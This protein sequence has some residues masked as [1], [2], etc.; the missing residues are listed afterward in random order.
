M[1]FLQVF[2]RIFCMESGDSTITPA[3][4][5]AKWSIDNFLAE[6]GSIRRYRKRHPAEVASCFANL[7]LLLDRLNFG[8]PFANI[9]YGFL[10]SEGSNVFRIGQT[11]LRHARE[12]RL[13]IYVKVVDTT[14]FV[15]T[16][17]DKDSQQDDINRCKKMTKGL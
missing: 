5:K 13:Y 9:E 1:Q 16:V 10:R 6:A 8:I 14:I 11:G 3:S 4:P 7:A 12:T 2:A 15:L 17:G